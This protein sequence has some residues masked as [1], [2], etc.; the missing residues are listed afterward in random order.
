MTER[1]PVL[2]S[3]DGAPNSG[4][5][6]ARGVSLSLMSAMDAGHRRLLGLVASFLLLLAEPF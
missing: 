5:R 2:R 6:R 4:D 1:S 3:H